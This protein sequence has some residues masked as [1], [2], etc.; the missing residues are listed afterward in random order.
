MFSLITRDMVFLL[1]AKAAHNAVR[2]YRTMI[3]ED[4]A[5][6]VDLPPWQQESI[7][8]ATRSIV[9]TPGITPSRL[10]A[11]WRAHRE[12]DGWTLGPFSYREKTHPNMLPY[13][14]LP[15]AQRLKDDLFLGVVR[16]MWDTMKE[17]YDD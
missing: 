12:L 6:W 4:D 11:L 8:F 17:L 13:E 15:V 3:G 2:L 5:A 9:E 16:L 14:S 1:C 7:L 10:H